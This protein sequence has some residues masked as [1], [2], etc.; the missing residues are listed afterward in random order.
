[1]R[2]SMARIVVV[3]ALVLIG[4]VAVSEDA[5]ACGRRCANVAPAGELP[6][7]RCIDDPSSSADCR[8]RSGS[9]GC[10]F[11]ACGL[12]STALPEEGAILASIFSDGS[13]PAECSG[14]PEEITAL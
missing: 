5:F 8:D 1:M 7:L 13:E 9:C 12:A 11:V 3:C 14:L 2:S 4:G 10:F 6:C